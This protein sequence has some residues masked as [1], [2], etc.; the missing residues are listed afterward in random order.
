MKPPS[1]G[2]KGPRAA[3]QGRRVEEQGYQRPSMMFYQAKKTY[4][5]EPKGKDAGDGIPSNP[6]GPDR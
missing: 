3:G 4:H 6:S 5:R 2:R 1:S